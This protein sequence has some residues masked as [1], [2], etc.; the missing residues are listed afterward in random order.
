MKPRSQHS[1]A[2]AWWRRPFLHLTRLERYEI[3]W[4]LIALAGATLLLV[5][6]KLA[7]E[8]MEGE[9]LAFDTK[10]L[11]ALRNPADPARMIGPPWLQ[12]ALL[13][14]TSLGSPVILGLVVLAVM[15]FLVLQTRYRTA[16]FVL[17]TSTSAWF[18]NYALKNSFARTRPSV[19]PHLRDVAS[20]S[21]PS[22]HALT[23]AVVYLT[24]GAVLM[25]VSKGRLTKI[26]CLTT[27]MILTLLTGISRVCLGVH[28]PTDV[29]AGWI[30]GLLWASLCWGAAQTLERRTGMKAEQRKADSG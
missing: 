14:L 23:S 28:Y 9:T 21:F 24:L 30:I 10:I 13:D 15:G 12:G 2:V 29:I 19:V 25:H 7:S 26:Y 1:G 8:V 27:A 6:L 22:G 11:R 17:L 3:S 18:V 16:L 20:T 4:L 5:F